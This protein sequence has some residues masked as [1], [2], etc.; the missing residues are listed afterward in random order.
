MDSFLSRNIIAALRFGDLSLLAIDADWLCALLHH[1]NVPVYM[2]E[3]FLTAYRSAVISVQGR[4]GHPIAEMLD[5]F[6][7]QVRSENERIVSAE[8]GLAKGA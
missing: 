7:E 5:I 6:L 3:R 2:L 8:Y 4:L 1:R